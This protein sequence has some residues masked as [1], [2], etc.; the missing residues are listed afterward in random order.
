[1]RFRTLLL[2]TLIGLCS[3]SVAHAKKHAPKYTHGNGHY[4][5]PKKFK[6]GKFKTPTQQKMKP[7]KW[8]VK[9]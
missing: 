8:G 7:A 6:P 3:F 1:V 2:A 4:K 9:R 5:K